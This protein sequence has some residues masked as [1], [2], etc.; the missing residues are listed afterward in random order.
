MG[1]LRAGDVYDVDKPKP[2]RKKH[3]V[4]PIV[5]EFGRYAVDSHSMAKRGREGTYIV[6]VLEKEETNAG[7]DHRDVRR[8]KAGQSGKTCS[9][10][11]GRARSSRKALSRRIAAEDLGLE[12]SGRKTGR[13]I[14]ARA[15]Y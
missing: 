11:R 15:S 2:E 3:K 14:T 10:S 1:L 4:T 13:M 7:D 9:S 6:D 5:G 12:E 8:A